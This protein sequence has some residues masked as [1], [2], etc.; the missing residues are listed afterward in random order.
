MFEIIIF[1][2]ILFLSAIGVSTVMG[3]LWLFL[4]KPKQRALTKL[5]VMLD[6]DDYQMQIGY[7]FEKYKWYGTNLADKIVFVC[8]KEP[9]TELLYLCKTFENF[10]YIV[11][12]K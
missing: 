9:S 7:E 4:V 2:A 3:R 12:D 8:K 11:E 6:E 1:V 5:L 10:E